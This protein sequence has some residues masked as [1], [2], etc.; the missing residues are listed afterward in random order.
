MKIPE[1][2]LLVS[3]FSLCPLLSFLIAGACNSTS[4]EPITAANGQDASPQ[5]A[6]T[7]EA[8]TTSD[9]GT[10][11]SLEASALDGS[12]DAGTTEDAGED[13]AEA[14]AAPTCGPPP[15]RYTLLTGASAGLVQDNVTGLVWMNDSVGGEQT[16]EQ[17]QSDAATY[18]AG[19]GMRL[20]T[21]AEAV[22]LA[23]NYASCAFGQ[24]S[25][26][27]S[28]AA[29]TGGDAWVV[30][31]LGDTSPQLADNFPSAVLCVRDST[32]D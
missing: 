29:G 21:E 6:G 24:W 27:T 5:D 8:P 20:P 30:D 12:F 17:T 25:T 11:T 18:C 3:L 28:T 26:W 13:A 2:S 7:H 1:S 10:G 31:Y 32:G 9:A 15:A 19:R 14:A 4:A 22:A 23:A 16:S